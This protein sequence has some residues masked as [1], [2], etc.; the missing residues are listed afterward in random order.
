MENIEQT[1]LIA[2]HLVDDFNQENSKLYC[3][4]IS[5]YGLNF[6]GRNVHPN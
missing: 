3:A 1:I 2:T 4:K 6:R 5:R